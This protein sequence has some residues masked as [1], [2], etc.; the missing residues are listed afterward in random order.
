M[1]MSGAGVIQMAQ[2]VV[3][4]PIHGVLLKKSVKVRESSEYNNSFVRIDERNIGEMFDVDGCDV[5]P[6]VNAGPANKL[7]D[8]LIKEGGIINDQD[9]IIKE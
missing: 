7:L 8:A 3:F 4:L 9:C 5:L 2:K 1:K 6:I